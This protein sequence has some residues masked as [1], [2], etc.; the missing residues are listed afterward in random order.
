MNIA[1]SEEQPL[2]SSPSQAPALSLREMLRF[3]FGQRD[4]IE[5]VAR[6]RAALSTG[7]ALV[8][9]TAIPRNY[10]QSFFLE[11]PL[12]LFGPPIFSAFS[13][14]FLFLILYHGF[15]RRHLEAPQTISKAAQWRSFMSLFWMTAPV[16]WLYAI[17]VE[18]FL[19]SYHAAQANLTLLA[20][21]S[22]WRVLLMARVSS[23]LLKIKFLR[24]LG[25]VLVPAC[26]EVLLVVV[27]SVVFGGRASQQIMAGMAGMRNAPEE[28]LI[29]LALGNVFTGA[30]VVLP[31]VVGLLAARRFSAGVQPFPK[32]AAAPL[33]VW[34][35][36]ALAA[37]WIAIAALPQLEQYHFVTHAQLVEAA[38]YRESV[39]Y[40]AQYARKDFPASRRMEPNPYEYQ[41]WEQLPEIMATL[42][43]SDPEW[44]RRLYLDH[45]EVMFSHYYLHSSFAGQVQML[46]ALERLP[47]G[48][49][50]IERNRSQLSKLDLADRHHGTDGT[51]DPATTL[52]LQ[53][54]RDSLQRLGVDPKSLD[55]SGNPSY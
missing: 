25:W 51:P 52:A 54:L 43:P 46:A 15:I 35:L 6:S 50:W 20:I 7:L 42:K 9:L 1:E 34:P 36:L 41:V 48:K 49:A 45:M 18:R 26:L 33:P 27:G 10:D 24:A 28:N 13:G 38:K 11:S 22:L 37:A 47:E 3:Q 5:T 55:Q 29:A 44:I 16:A 12:W 32:P 2:C 23:V 31:A 30:L 8:L 53:Q 14:T 21:V 39:D 4:A 40:L 17:P 19:N